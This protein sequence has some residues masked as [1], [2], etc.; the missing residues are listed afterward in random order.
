[1]INKVGLYI[2]QQ[3]K[4]FIN[5][6]YEDYDKMIYHNYKEIAL[7][8]FGT[9]NDNDLSHK[10]HDFI[11]KMREKGSKIV[12]CQEY[13]E[14]IYKSKKVVNSNLLKNI[15]NIPNYTLI[16]KGLIIKELP[17][18]ISK[19]NEETDLLIDTNIDYDKDMLSHNSTE[20]LNYLYDKKIKLIIAF[21][22]HNNMFLYN[23]SYDLKCFLR[24][25]FPIIISNDLCNNL[26]N[27]LY[28]DIYNNISIKDYYEKHICPTIN[29]NELIDLNKKT[30]YID[31]DNTITIGDNY[32]DCI[33]IIDIVI[34]L[35]TLFEENKYNII[36]WTSRG[37][38]TNK[39]YYDFTK[40]QLN[41]WN[42]K[43]NLLITKK[44]F[45]DKF[46]DEKSI[47][48]DNTNLNIIDEL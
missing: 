40:N 3:F 23:N 29:S 7:L 24:Y 41:E 46:I 19:Q 39:D 48:L 16:D 18:N 45:F 13:S 8:S 28:N 10:S 32:E 5:N 33:C 2:R 14:S 42:V 35:N 21:G 27:N 26:N 11:K 1:M 25:G 43:Y 47:N 30:L 22:N 15:K 4:T 38:I 37:C 34:K 20:I 6:Q 36:Y 31:I 44:P 9:L 17:I 12:Y